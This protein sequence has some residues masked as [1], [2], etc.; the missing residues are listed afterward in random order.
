MLSEPKVYKAGQTLDDT[1]GQDI[2]LDAP[3]NVSLVCGFALSIAM[4]YSVRSC[5]YSVLFL[6]SRHPA[7]RPHVPVGLRNVLLRSKQRSHYLVQDAKG[8]F[9]RLASLVDW[10]VR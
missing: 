4:L 2:V 3:Y 1:K 10:K 5:F 6:A 9:F 7:D 8:F